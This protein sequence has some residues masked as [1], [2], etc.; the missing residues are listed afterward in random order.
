MWSGER[1]LWDQAKHE[2]GCLHTP[3]LCEICYRQVERRAD[4]PVFSPADGWGWEIAKTHVSV[5]DTIAGALYYHHAR[6]HI[7]AEPMVLSMHRHLAENHPLKV[8]L[9]PHFMGTL[10]INEVGYKTVFASHGA[11]DWFTGGSRDS[12][13]KMVVDSVQ[14]FHFD[15]SVF[16]SELADRGVDDA[17]LLPDYP[18][19]DDGLLVWDALASWVRDY[20]GL[21]YQ[22]DAAVLGDVELQSW[23]TEVTAAD[24]GGLR[25]IGQNGRI[26]DRAYLIKMLTQIIFSGSALHAAMNFPVK[27]EMSFVPNSPWG[28][29]GVV[30][31]Q[32][33]GWTEQDWLDNLPP[34]AQAQRQFAVAHLLGASRYGFLGDYADTTFSDPRVAAPLARFRA[35]LKEVESTITARNLERPEYIHM[36]PSRMPPSINI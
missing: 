20:V 15:R 33:K 3:V 7:V 13:R 31:Q 22:D 29:Y 11:L 19:R 28:A 32:T 36:L 35:G 18:F 6:A 21:Y 23:L 12:I 8:L 30:P 9:T 27:E 10:Y 2:E 14:S 25:G 16:R 4:A 17:E 34:M 24:A 26:R 5:A 1:R